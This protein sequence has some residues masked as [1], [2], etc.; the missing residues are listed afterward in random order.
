MLSPGRA[1]SVVS[2]RSLGRVVAPS[3]HDTKIVSRP[4]PL[5]R[6]LHAV[7]HTVSQRCVALATARIAAL[8]RRITR[9]WAPYR[10][11]VVTQGRLSPHDTK[12]VSRL[13]P[14]GQAMRTRAAARPERKLAVSQG[15]LAV[16]WPC[17]DAL[18]A[19]LWP[20]CSTPNPAVSRYNLLYRD[21]SQN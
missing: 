19:V 15:L 7:S 4:K 17:R 13:T 12:F 14:S 18:L 6:A 2:Q 10:S 11:R 5:L 3:G 1:H 16:S 21:P 9:R 20:P 8:L